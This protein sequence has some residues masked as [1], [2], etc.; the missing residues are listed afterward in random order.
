MRSSAY[1]GLLIGACL[2]LCLFLLLRLGWL[3]LLGEGIPTDDSLLN[4]LLIGRMLDGGYPWERFFRDAYTNGHLN[5]FPVLAQ[6]LWAWLTGW[7]FR[8]AL[9]VGAALGLTKVFLLHS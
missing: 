9:L 1:R 5:V 3:L 2:L 4:A 7:N 6:Y 8:L